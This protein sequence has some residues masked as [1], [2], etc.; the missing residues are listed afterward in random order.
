MTGG[1]S[2]LSSSSTAAQADAAHFGLW[3]LSFG[4][5]ISFIYAAHGKYTP[6][7]IASM[8]AT[9]DLSSMGNGS[10]Q[11]PV[12]GPGSDG[13]ITLLS[14]DEL[15]SFRM[16]MQPTDRPEKLAGV[17]IYAVNRPPVD[18]YNYDTLK[19]LLIDHNCSTQKLF[20]ESCTD[21]APHGAP[22][23]EYDQK[24]HL[25]FRQTLLHESIE[26]PITLVQ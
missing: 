21:G 8:E 24:S 14:D 11:D 13:V 4:G 5:I 19:A 18:T 2:R 3:G 20:Y 6:T 15:E 17:Y 7:I 23:Q 9:P 26:G 1:A 25:A 22:M 10:D 16:S 12:F